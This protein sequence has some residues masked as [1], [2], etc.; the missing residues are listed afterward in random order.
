MNRNAKFE[1]KK[2]KPIRHH[3]YYKLLVLLKLNKKSQK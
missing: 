3:K 1:K 2:D